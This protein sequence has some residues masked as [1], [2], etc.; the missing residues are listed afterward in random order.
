M[1]TRHHAAF[2]IAL[3]R[4]KVSSETMAIYV[5]FNT[6]SVER[7]NMINIIISI[8]YISKV[9]DASQLILY[10][11]PYYLILT[12]QGSL[13]QGSGRIYIPKFKSLSS[14]GKSYGISTESVSPPTPSPSKSN[15]SS[16]HGQPSSLVISL[17]SSIAE[18]SS[19]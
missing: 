7:S 17:I 5:T 10:V 18:G 6:N 15:S 1:L 19:C 13:I 16:S 9:Y 8:A 2:A 12:S 14:E 4:K 3:F 11:N